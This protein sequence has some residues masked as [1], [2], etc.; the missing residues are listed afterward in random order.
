MMWLRRMGGIFLEGNG[1]LQNKLSDRVA[2]ITSHSK[3]TTNHTK[4][5]TQVHSLVVTFVSLRYDYILN[6]LHEVQLHEEVREVHVLYPWDRIHLQIGPPN[7]EFYTLTPRI[8]AMK[9]NS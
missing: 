9:S 5:I 3:K 6:V 4:I 1:I 7:R 2:K 8:N